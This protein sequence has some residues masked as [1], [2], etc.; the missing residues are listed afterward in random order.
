MREFPLA[1]AGKLAYHTG[2]AGHGHQQGLGR[3]PHL[4]PHSGGEP[5][6]GGDQPEA[7]DTPEPA[8]VWADQGEPQRGRQP[9]WRY[10]ARRCERAADVLVVD[11]PFGQGDPAAQRRGQPAGFAGG[12]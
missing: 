7:A 3:T 12:L 5:Q 10:R 6:V 8:D 1:R 2:T 11:E 4:G 9:F